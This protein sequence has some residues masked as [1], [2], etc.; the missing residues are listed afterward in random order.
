MKLIRLVMK[1]PDHSVVL[2]VVRLLCCT[3]CRKS[4]VRAWKKPERVEPMDGGVIYKGPL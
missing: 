2:Y 4:K 3:K 1:G